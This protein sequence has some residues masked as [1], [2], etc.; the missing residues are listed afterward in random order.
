[1]KNIW[2]TEFK[3]GLTVI[4]GTLILIFGIIWGK[5]FKLETDTYQLDVY[6]ENIGGMVLGEMVT[7]NGFKVGTVKKIEPYGRYVLTTL[8]IKDDVELYEDADF[9]IISAELL[10][11]MRV[12]IFP[13]YS[14]KLLDLSKQ[15]IKGRYGG[16]I[17]DVGLT[18]DQLARDMSILTFRLDT[19]VILVNGFLKKGELQKG[20]NRT[21]ANLDSISFLFKELLDDNSGSFHQSMLNF[22][23]TSAS[24]NALL[25]S[26]STSLNKTFKNLTAVTTRLDTISYSLQMVLQK[27]DQKNGTLGKMVNDTTLY[28][29]LNRTLARIDSLA[30][31]IKDEGLDID[32][33]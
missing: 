12:E 24:L 17:V 20:V 33:F 2:T 19:T 21:M 25:D 4:T 9:V 30:K 31:V 28:N 10:A 1:M 14:D 27:I 16:R 23:K 11:G 18:I 6:F 29:N 22:E 3:V 15:P 26:N 7:A 8:E 13:G 32:L 5:G